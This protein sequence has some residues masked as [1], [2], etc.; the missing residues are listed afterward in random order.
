MV[1]TWRGIFRDG[2]VL[3]EGERLLQRVLL[4]GGHSVEEEEIFFE[5]DNQRE[6]RELEESSREKRSVSAGRQA[7]IERKRLEGGEEV[8]GRS[9]L[10]RYFGVVLEER[11]KRNKTS[12]LSGMK[13][14]GLLLV[15]DSHCSSIVAVDILN[16]V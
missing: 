3:L 7:V 15:F 5:K 10:Q 8:L 6:R 1:D 13:A 16:V 4:R 11:L 9:V 12:T 2:Y 14:K